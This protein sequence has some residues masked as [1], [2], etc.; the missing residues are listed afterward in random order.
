MHSEDVLLM[1]LQRLYKIGFNTI[2][3]LNL[4]VYNNTNL[5]LGMSQPCLECSK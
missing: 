1:K 5:T 4:T 2:N 3:I